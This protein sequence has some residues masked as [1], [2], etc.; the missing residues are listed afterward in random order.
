MGNMVDISSPGTLN[1]SAEISI[2]NL[3]GQREV[4]AQTLDLSNGS[5]LLTL[6]EN[7]NGVHIISVIV[8]GKRI[9]K[10]LVF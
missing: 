2:V 7:L 6:P 4:L 1:T 3:L 8:D 5:N 10:K 9:S